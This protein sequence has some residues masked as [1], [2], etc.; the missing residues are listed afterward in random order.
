MKNIRFADR[1]LRTPATLC[2]KD[3][4]EL[5]KLLDRLKV[6]VIELP[7]PGTNKGEQ[8][9]NKTLASVVSGS[10]VSVCAGRTEDAIEAAWETVRGAKYP[11]LQICV[12]VSPVQMEY[13]CHKKA[14]ALL[15]MI[16]ALIRKARYYCENVEFTAEDATRAEFNV[17]TD[18]IRIALEAGANKITVCDSAG[19]MLPQE[20]ADFIRA[21]HEA[22]PALADIELAVE[23]HD[24][25]HMAVACAAAAI[26]A[27]ADV[28]K[29]TADGAG[30]P[31]M[32]EISRFIQQRGAS[33]NIA[34]NLRVTELS[35]AAKQM[36]W[37]LQAE[38]NEQSAFNDG[39][40]TETANL[41]LDQND[42]ITEVIKAVRQLGYELTDED[43]AKVYEAFQRLAA[44]KRF[45]GTKELEAIVASSAMQVP[46]TYRISN[47][48]INCGDI[49]TATANIELE[50]D[51]KKV[52][53]IGVGDGPIDAAFIAIEHII[54]H[55]YELDDFQIQSVTE[56][57]EAMGSALVKLRSD[58]RL[59]SGNGIS[60]DI[61]G[62]SIR[63][64]VNALNK[65]MYE[66]G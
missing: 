6:D 65:I 62:A 57:K 7:E 55:H 36:Q 1:T 21:L 5:V 11:A 35:R 66:E 27:G 3:K 56:G 39:L 30:F 12:P 50:K 60:T 37:L 32:E 34:Q 41:C 18:A 29:T 22:V 49:I 64:Y 33:L 2:F 54:G 4:L 46:S 47:Y 20:I 17:V 53:G 25:L 14:P 45:V 31:A 40:N 28:I 24:D 51:G 13:E 63:A 16:G 26:D 38:K 61:I 15:E 52:R 8:L 59:Y 43:N 10:M 44:K 48:V 19:T 9:T 42:S 23:L 58:G